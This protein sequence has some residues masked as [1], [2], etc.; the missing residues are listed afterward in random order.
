MLFRSLIKYKEDQEKIWQGV[1]EGIISLVCSDHAP[2]TAQQ[3]DGKL[4]EIPAGMCGVETLAPMMIDAVSKGKISI[5]QLVSLLSENPAKL[6]GIYPEKGSL[7][8]G[9]DGDITIIDMNKKYTIKE[10]NLHSVSKITAFDGLEVKGK[11]VGT[12]VRGRT[13]MKDGKIVSEPFGKFIKGKGE[14]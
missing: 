6:F 12:I 9:S 4:W 5:N 11:P 1:Q 8:I 3:K 7:Q 14:I 2:H 10:E 13:V